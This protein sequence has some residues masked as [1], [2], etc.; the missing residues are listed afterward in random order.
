[1]RGRNRTRHSYECIP[2]FPPFDC[3]VACPSSS[4]SAVSG[5][6]LFLGS[7][8]G[9]MWACFKKP[10]SQNNSSS[11]NSM[12]PHTTVL[13][14][15]HLMV[16]TYWRAGIYVSLSMGM[17]CKQS[18]SM[19]INMYS[20]VCITW[21]HSILFVSYSQ[22]TAVQLSAKSM[23]TITKMLRSKSVWTNT[24]QETLHLHESQFNLLG[25]HCHY[26]FRLGH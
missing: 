1:M 3:E 8:T 18:P 6:V 22:T 26:H 25:C 15:H 17:A 14:R 7:C 10:P 11:C 4:P 2:K 9:C 21:Q 24:I 20:R 23:T 16:I 13:D 19:Y 12:T 5:T